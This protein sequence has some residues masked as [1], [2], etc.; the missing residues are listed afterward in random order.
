MNAGFN[1]TGISR[2]N[3]DD[4]RRLREEAL[5][6]GPTHVRWFKAAVALMDGFPGIY[7]VAKTMNET[8]ERQ[9]ELVT[10][11]RGQ[12]GVLVDLLQ[13]AVAVCRTVEPADGGIVERELLDA[14]I[15]RA[16][17]LIRQVKT[18]ALPSVAAPKCGAADASVTTRRGI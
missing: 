7:E 11:L 14:L 16:E 12:R 4:L 1:F 8:A 17:V 9:R 10:A 5:S 2:V 15:S 6:V 13:D 18:E 3:L